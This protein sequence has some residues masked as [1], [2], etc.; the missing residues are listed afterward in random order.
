MKTIAK[1]LLKYFPTLCVEILNEIGKQQDE[2][3]IEEK[4][5]MEHHSLNDERMQAYADDTIYEYE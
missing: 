4:E 1:L 5:E 3:R 2:Q